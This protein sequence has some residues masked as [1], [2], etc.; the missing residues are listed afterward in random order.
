MENKFKVGDKVVYKNHVHYGAYSDGFESMTVVDLTLRGDVI[1]FQTDWY[2]G[3]RKITI[4]QNEL[5]LESEANEKLAQLEKDWN[6]LEPVITG[7]IKQATNVFHE[8]VALAA[9]KG[10]KV[11]DFDVMYEVRG[12]TRSGG[13]SSSAFSC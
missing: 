1:I 12:M 2:Q 9:E 6:E 13:W 5:I 8:A 11:A 3:T 10:F 4:D 7:K